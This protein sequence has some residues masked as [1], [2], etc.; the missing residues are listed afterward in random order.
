LPNTAP[1]DPQLGENDTGYSAENRIF[2]RRYKPQEKFTFVYIDFYT[3]WIM[4]C[5]A[6]RSEF[7]TN[8]LQGRTQWGGLG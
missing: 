2:F 7:A 1:L 8:Y 6:K 3:I 4:R 5:Y